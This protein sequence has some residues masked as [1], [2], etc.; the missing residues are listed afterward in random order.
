VKSVGGFDPLVGSDLA[1]VDLAWRLKIAG[2][3]AMHEP[4]SVIYTQPASLR[5]SEGAWQRGVH[6]ERLFWR[7][8]GEVG[9]SRALISHAGELAASVLKQP[10]NPAWMIELAARA[11]AACQFGQHL[12]HRHRLAKLRAA[13]PR[14]VLLQGPHF[15]SRVDAECTTTRK[16]G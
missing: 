15:R 13:N 14:T 16:A 2:F 5:A 6:A 11:K 10:W 3:R 8:A 1:D 4:Q 7:S 12:E 9:W